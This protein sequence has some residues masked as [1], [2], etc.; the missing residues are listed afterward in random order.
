VLDLCAQPARVLRPGMIHLGS[1]RGVLGARGVRGGEREP[2][3]ASREPRR[4]PGLLRKHYSPKARLVIRSWKDEADFNA[5]IAALDFPRDRVYVLAHTVIPAVK[6]LGRVRAVPGDAE[7]F[8]R[9]IYAEL[10]RC[11]DEGA[12]VIVVEALPATAEWQG[13]ADRLHRAAGSQK[14]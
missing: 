2:A 13:I 8:A 9:S 3:V 7:G 1:L 12:A 4:S 5:Q 14:A 11:D 10:H 6:G